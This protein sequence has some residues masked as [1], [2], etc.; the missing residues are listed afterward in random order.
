MSKKKVTPKRTPSPRIIVV[1]DDVT[2]TVPPPGVR[3]GIVLP[4]RDTPQENVSITAA[5]G[6]STIPVSEWSK[7]YGVSNLSY[8]AQSLYNQASVGSCA[9]ESCDKILEMVRHI[10]G[11]PF[12]LFNPYGAYGRL[13]GGV[14]GGS[15][16]RENL[17]FART[18]GAFPESVWPRSKGWRPEPSQEAY[19]E[20]KKYRIHEYYE[21]STWEQFGSALLLGWIVYWGYTGHAIVGCDLLSESKFRY[22]NSW[23]NWGSSSPHNDKLSAGFGI[24]SASQIYWGYGVYAVRTP[25]V[26]V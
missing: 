10:S 16:L 25:V 1:S 11:L 20:A 6:F 2:S 8:H 14:D 22:L 9:A 3:Q 4:R 5:N 23:G 7:W 19:A 21:V 13:N 17:E 12:V 15:T 18:K 26:E 24:A